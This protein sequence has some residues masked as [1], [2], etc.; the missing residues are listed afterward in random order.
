MSR[1]VS[2]LFRI[3][4]TANFTQLTGIQ[5]KTPTARTFVDLNFLLDAEEVPHHNNVAT[6]R[7]VQPLRMV[8]HDAF[9]SFDVQQLFTR[10]LMRLIEFL[11]LKIVKPDTAT[12]TLAHVNHNISY[13][14]FL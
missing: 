7:T 9:V 5:P 6:F 8:N 1:S 3:E 12:A 11:K 13:G 10:R 4:Q 14:H 2:F